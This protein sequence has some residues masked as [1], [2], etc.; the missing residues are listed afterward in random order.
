MYTKTFI[1]LTI[2][3]LVTFTSAKPLIMQD[4]AIKTHFNLHKIIKRNTGGYEVPT[5]SGFA[6]ITTTSQMQNH[7]KKR[8]CEEWLK[9]EV[10][11]QWKCVKFTVQKREN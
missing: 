2:V 5:N 10:T 1:I 9:E 6:V 11:G 7:K 8:E 4:S 3:F